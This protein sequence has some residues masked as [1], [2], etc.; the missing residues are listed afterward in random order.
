MLFADN[1]LRTAS[2]FASHWHPVHSRRT[3]AEVPRYQRGPSSSAAA[4]R[5]A[6]RQRTQPFAAQTCMACDGPL[7]ASTAPD[8]NGLLLCGRCVKF[9]NNAKP[10]KPREKVVPPPTRKEALAEYWL[11]AQTLADTSGADA[12]A[13]ARLAPAE[14]V[15]ALQ[16]AIEGLPTAGPARRRRK[17]TPRKRRHDGTLE[18]P[19]PS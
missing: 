8:A 13:V 1:S 11:V 12:D 6:K 16:R 3:M 17:G 5:D 14:K 18:P 7:A 19:A 9:N 2:S 4:P 15:D 10:R